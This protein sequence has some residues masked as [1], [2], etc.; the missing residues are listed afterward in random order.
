MYLQVQRERGPPVRQRA[1]RQPC[2]Q[3]LIEV[4]L[5]EGRAGLAAHAADVVA[6]QVERAQ[7]AEAG[8]GVKVERAEKVAAQ[9]AGKN[10][11]RG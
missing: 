8:Q 1:R 6:A 2:Q 10:I 11:N 4:E 3:I 9:V 7:V 5:L